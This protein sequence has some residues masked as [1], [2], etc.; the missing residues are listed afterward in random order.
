MQSNTYIRII[1]LSIILSEA[2]ALIRKSQYR[3]AYKFLNKPFQEPKTYFRD[4]T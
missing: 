1:P 2:N 4:K 3:K